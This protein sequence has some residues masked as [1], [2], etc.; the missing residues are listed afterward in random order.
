[1]SL[2]G[3]AP[4]SSA[5]RSNVRSGPGVTIVIQNYAYH[6]DSLTVRAGT[7]V[8]VVNRDLTQ[9]TLT[10]DDGAFDTGTVQPGQTKRLTPRRL[11]KFPYH[12]DFHAFMTGTIAVVR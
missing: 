3:L 9:H 1:M 8:R 11:G 12:C 7:T 6:Q 10:A 5:Q 4:T 2:A